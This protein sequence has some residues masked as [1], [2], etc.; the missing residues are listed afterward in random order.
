MTG[1]AVQPVHGIGSPPNGR[2]IFTNSKGLVG[3]GL[4]RRKEKGSPDPGWEDVR[5]MKSGTVEVTIDDDTI[6]GG[7]VKRTI[8]YKAPFDR[9]D[10]E[11]DYAL[12]WAEFHR[13]G[14]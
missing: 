12:A 7:P 1:H 11:A 8:T 6:P 4:S 2:I 5:D 14:L 13:R 10:R 3:V 9:C